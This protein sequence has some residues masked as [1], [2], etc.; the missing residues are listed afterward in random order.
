MF[1]SSLETTESILAM[2]AESCLKVALKLDA[3]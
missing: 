3:H 2:L 1:K